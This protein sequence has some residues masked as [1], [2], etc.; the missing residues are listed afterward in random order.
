MSAMHWEA[1]RRQSALD[2]RMARDQQQVNN[3]LYKAVIQC[4]QSKFLGQIFFL[5]MMVFKTAKMIT[6]H[7]GL[8][9]NGTSAVDVKNYK[10]FLHLYILFC[11]WWSSS[12][13]ALLYYWTKAGTDWKLSGDTRHP[14]TGSNL[15]PVWSWQLVSC[16][17]FPVCV[18]T[19][20]YIYYSWI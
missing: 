12:M 7:Q 6:L 20:K 1:R 4:Q 16:C 11:W 2:R 19:Q 9:K 18:Q 10:T 14:S 8:V 3:M 15:F 17:R 5:S 13:S